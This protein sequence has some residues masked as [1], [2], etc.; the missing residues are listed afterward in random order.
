VSE[1]SDA[2]TVTLPAGYPAELER[3][4]RAADGTRVL[5]RPLRPDDLDRELAFIAG[6]SENTLY[7]RVQYSAREIRREEAA[8][9]LDLD[10]RDQLAIGALVDG[11]AGQKIV[12]VSRCARIDDTD[13]AECAIVVDDAWQGRGIGT[14]LVR[15]LVIGARAMGIRTLE[16]STLAQNQPIHAWASR[17]GLAMQTEPN[18]GGQVRVTLD[19][20]SFLP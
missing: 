15:S 12:G 13:R 3:T 10:Y 20:R 16:G 1:S 2:G 18:S 19:V 5:L 17:F 9:L 6:L 11:D 4:W 14:E 8:R 7:L